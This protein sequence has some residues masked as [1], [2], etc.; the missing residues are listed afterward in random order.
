[1][2]V[3]KMN[4]FKEYT[5]L[6]HRKWFLVRQL[7]HW[8]THLHYNL[9]AD[10]NDGILASIIT[11]IDQKPFDLCIVVSFLKFYFVT[12]WK[13]SLYTALRCLYTRSLC[14]SLRRSF[15]ILTQDWWKEGRNMKLETRP[16]LTNKYLLK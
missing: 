4:N 3:L 6:T 5:I 13:L 16:L 15:V 7:W 9:I 1:M 8:A 2:M 12:N 10:S 11:E 14:I